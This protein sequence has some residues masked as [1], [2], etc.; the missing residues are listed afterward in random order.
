[1]K[2][3]PRRDLPGPQWRHR[4]LAW[5][6]APDSAWNRA[7]AAVEQGDPFCCRTEW[8]LSYDE[9]FDPGRRLHLLEGDDSV[10]AFAERGETDPVPL[11]VPVESSWLF[12]NPLLG[13]RALDLLE[14]FLTTWPELPNL[15]LS[16]LL[17]HGRL[18]RKVVRRLGRHYQ[19]LP[20]EPCIM[21]SAS[22][23]GGLDGFLSR[24]SRRLRSNLRAAGRRAAD[25][26]IVFER[27]AP[28][29]VEAAAAAY[30]RILAV[31]AT[32]WKGIGEC[33]MAES[34]SREFYGAMLRRLAAAG[35]GR[36][37]FARIDDRDVGFIFG[38]IAGDVYRGQQFSYDDALAGL[39]IG[40]LL[41]VEKIRWLVEDGVTRYDMGPLME[42]KLHWTEI[43][44]RIE[45]HVLLG[46]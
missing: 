9:A 33:G 13:P 22:L 2:P 14:S 42:Y 25:R 15:L 28:T 5:F 10:V 19:I 46:R 39:S 1:M 34:P 3:P 24:R 41:A 11:L 6:D 38:G 8:Q 37:I 16:G 17:P 29:T 7:A 21:R 23:A 27:H 45:V 12:A 35:N 26:G 43:E 44:T 18:L 32:S 40:N 4:D 30:E 36:V 31:E 20:L